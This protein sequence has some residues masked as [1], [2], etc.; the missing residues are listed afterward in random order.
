MHEL[1]V[2][3]R[4]NF[5]GRLDCVRNLETLA[6]LNLES[7]SQEMPRRLQSRDARTDLY[8]THARDDI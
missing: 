7:G 1:P 2:P 3:E 4:F 8:N 5:P 6:Y